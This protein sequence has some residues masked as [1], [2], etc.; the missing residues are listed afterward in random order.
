MHTEHSKFIKAL[1]EV[2]PLPPELFSAVEAGLRRT[3]RRR[4]VLALA[5]LLA[6]AVLLPTAIVGSLPAASVS[7]TAAVSVSDTLD[8]Y[9]AILDDAGSLFHEDVSSDAEFLAIALD[10]YDSD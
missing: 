2:P 4:I 10:S 9:D 6:L 3:H 1:G 7:A 8:T 5:A